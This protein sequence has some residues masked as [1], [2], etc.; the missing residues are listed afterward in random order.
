MRPWMSLARKTRCGSPQ[1][2]RLMPAASY[3]SKGKVKF[4]SVKMASSSIQ[5]IHSMFCVTGE[6]GCISM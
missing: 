5:R 1:M 6:S 2:T 4:M 3:S